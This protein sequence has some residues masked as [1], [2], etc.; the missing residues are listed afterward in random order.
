MGELSITFSKKVFNRVVEALAWDGRERIVYVLCEASQGDDQTKLLPNEIMSPSEDDYES[1]SAVHL[2][3]KKEF[4]SKVGNCAVE[5]QRHILQAHV[6][7]P[8]Y[9]GRYSPVDRR[10]EPILMKHVAEKIEGIIHASMVFSSDFSELDS[11]YFD[12]KRGDVVPTS[13]IVVVGEN[14]LRLFIPTG[15]QEDAAPR[16][17]KQLSRTVK[18]YGREAVTML[19]NLTIGIVGVSGL[20]SPVADNLIRDGVVRIILCDPDTIEESNLNRLAGATQKDVGRFKVD[21]F[22][23]YAAEISPEAEVIAIKDSFYSGKAQS[24]FAQADIIFGAVD[25]GA[26]FSINSLALANLIAYIDTGATVLH[27]GGKMAFLGGQAYS[28]IPGRH[29]CLSCAG[30]FNDLWQEYLP[31]DERDREA[32]QGYLKG[33]PE[34]IPLVMSLDHV[35][36]GLAY[37]QMLSYIWGETAQEVFGVHYDGLKATITKSVCET[38]GCLICQ[39]D[40]AL[41]MGDKVEPVVPRK[42]GSKEMRVLP[43]A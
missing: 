28:V 3:V 13:K 21:F 37:Q 2:K 40:G 8:G 25:S 14:A 27:E 35:I 9:G 39:E 29:V 5:T 7:P 32:R 23:D 4:I 22:K 10:E 12:R 1:R 15:V 19:K 42:D 18:A 6:H 11:W 17:P 30:V 26:R 43:A 31:P 33:L 34:G 36:A 38:G 16:V 20:G 24:V 41:G